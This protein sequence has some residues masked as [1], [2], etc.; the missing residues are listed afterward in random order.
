[1]TLIEKFHGFDLITKFLE[2]WLMGV[3]RSLQTNNDNDWT[4][5]GAKTNPA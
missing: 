3:L 5:A 1:M 4:A 2:T